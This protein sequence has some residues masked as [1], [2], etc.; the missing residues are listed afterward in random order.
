M[1]LDGGRAGAGD[2]PAEFAVG[3][4]QRLAANRSSPQRATIQERS[5]HSAA[6]FVR[7]DFIF[8]TT[9]AAGVARGP[10]VV[11]CR[12]GREALPLSGLVLPVRAGD[13][14]RAGRQIV[15]RAAGL[16]DVRS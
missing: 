16:S 3:I 4:A 2:L 9:G 12:A 14:H 10:V 11:F 5:D 7:T 1:D 13:F 6:I 8:A 15:L